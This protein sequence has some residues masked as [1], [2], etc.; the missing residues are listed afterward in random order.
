MGDELMAQ[1]SPMARDL[2]S[3]KYRQRVVKNRKV[4]TRK[5]KHKKAKQ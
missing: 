1:R 3:A 4:Y 2:A 5:T